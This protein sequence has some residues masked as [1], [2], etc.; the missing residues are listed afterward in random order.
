MQWVLI[1]CDVIDFYHEEQEGHEEKI[2][3][4]RSVVCIFFTPTVSVTTIKLT[5][6]FARRVHS[7]HQQ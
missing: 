4:V 6:M 2:L 3:G 1:S 5:E 7:M